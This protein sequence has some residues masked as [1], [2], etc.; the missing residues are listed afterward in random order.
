MNLHHSDEYKSS[1]VNLRNIDDCIFF[2][3]ERHM[4]QET[5]ASTKKA[6]GRFH[7]PTISLSDYTVPHFFDPGAAVTTF[8][9][10]TISGSISAGNPAT[11][12]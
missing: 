9:A 6:R 8:T 2:K 5:N 12:S 7:P 10:S 1:V 4:D 11:I 3:R